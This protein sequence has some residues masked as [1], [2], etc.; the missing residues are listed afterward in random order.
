M[1]LEGDYKA[2]VYQK[3]ILYYFVYLFTLVFFQ[4]RLPSALS[5]DSQEV[6]LRVAQENEIRGRL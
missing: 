4:I 5:L 1:K 2:G 6:W 3:R